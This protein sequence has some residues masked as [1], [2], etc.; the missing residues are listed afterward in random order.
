MRPRTLAALMAALGALGASAAA[1]A[2]EG[3]PKPTPAPVPASQ[4]VVIWPTLTPA[5]DAA[6]ATTLHK[7]RGENERSL[8]ARAQEL[9]AT[10]R[11]GVQDLG[12]T[13]YVADDAIPPGHTRDADLIERA[14]HA[15]PGGASNSGTWVV[16][17]RIEAAGGEQYLVRIVVVPPNGKELRVRVDTVAGDNV[18]VRGLTLLRDL[19]Q[20]STAA[21]AVIEHEK[22]RI[23]T[24]ARVGVVS[25]T[26]SEGRAIL[27]INSAL[28]GGFVGFSIES[29][30]GSDD[31]R[32]LYPLLALGTGIGIGAALLVAEEW[33]VT[34]GDAWILSAGAWWGAASGIFIANGLHVAPFTNRYSWGVGGGFIGLG[35]ATTVLVKTKMDDGDAMLVHS[36]GAVGL[37]LG[38][39]ADL[40]YRGT[41]TDVTPFTGMGYGAAIGLIGAGVIATR[42]ST[43]PTRVLLVDL[44]TGL[45]ALAGAALASPLIFEDLS[46]DK[47]RAWLA[48]TLAGS[49]AGG[50]LAFFLTQGTD[51][52]KSAW[53]P[54][55]TPIAGVIGTSE[56]RTGNVPAYGVGWHASF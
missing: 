19:L 21:A 39:L 18:S 5:G 32:V 28:F 49:I 14:S 36:G 2:D 29:A 7:P 47:T 54:P 46:E 13:L 55:G 20:A 9:D 41:T 15:G 25:P 12:L 37:F 35:L 44:G 23:D 48:A 27:A 56:T 26:R 17:P 4:S 3:H 31:P 8:A 16:S 6:S 24:S 50:T 33:D 51:R 38:A 34:A 43:T 42:V 11:D 53:L 40:A 10:L 45:G 52:G 22:E 1:R 30:A